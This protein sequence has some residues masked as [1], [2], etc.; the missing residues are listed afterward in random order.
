MFHDIACVATAALPGNAR[1]RHKA[2]LGGR[3]SQPMAIGSNPIHSL[4]E[5]ACP[6]NCE[7]IPLLTLWLKSIQTYFFCI[8]ED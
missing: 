1:K 6:H 5:K 8:R 3:A 2:A 4:S 7:K